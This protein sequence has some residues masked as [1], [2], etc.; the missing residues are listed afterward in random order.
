MYPDDLTDM[1]GMQVI[2]SEAVGRDNAIVMEGEP[3]FNAKVAMHPLDFYEMGTPPGSLKRLEKGLD[4]LLAEAN[5]QLDQL[6][7]RLAA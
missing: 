5:R 2:L 1:T 4:Y 3:W 6:E 7:A